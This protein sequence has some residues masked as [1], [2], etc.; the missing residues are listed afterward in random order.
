MRATHSAGSQPLR[1]GAIADAA[2]LEDWQTDCLERLARVDG[3]TP[4]RHPLQ[5]H[6]LEQ[7]SSR[8][9]LARADIVLSFAAGPL[10]AWVVRA[11]RLG[12]WS[13]HFGAWQRTPR[14]GGCTL[15]TDGLASAALVRLTTEPHRA[16]LLR[17]GFYRP[18]PKHSATLRSMQ[19]HATLWPSQVCIDLLNGERPD[20]DLHAPVI[21]LDPPRAPA[22]HR[23]PS[24]AIRETLGGLAAGA[25]KTLLH[26]HWSV[27][28][29]RRPIADFLDVGLRPQI[30][31]LPLDGRRAFAADPFGLLHEGRHVALYE[32]YDRRTGRGSIASFELTA[33][34]FANDS[35]IALGPEIHRSYPY[36]FEHE[37]AIY[38]IPETSAAREVALYRAEEYPRRW[39]R[40][41]T[42]LAGVDA[43][44]STVFR[45]EGRWW[46]AC[47]SAAERDRCADL[48][49][50]HAEALEGPWRSHAGNP[51]KSDVRSARPG[52]TPFVHEYTLYRP[53]QDC[54]RTYGGR[55]VINRVLRLSP[56][57]FEEEPAAIVSPDP[58]G[59][60]PDGLHTLSAFGGLTLLDGKR[61]A[62]VPAELRRT[63]TGLWKPSTVMNVDRG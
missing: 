9:D 37:G 18:E 32:R 42:L 10:P 33:A 31:W 35:A 2:R 60:F 29:V 24:A 19:T 57:A 41:A 11:P 16:V 34:G 47:A 46:L 36:V 50:W 12:V 7:A 23:A 48:F 25:L 22:G 38:G 58:A 20:A 62:L 63:L 45:H 26:E 59:P 14:A 52:G 21:L 4:A 15:P 54:S 13:F 28:V 30:Q 61:R 17:E 8:D 3:I 53:A 44:D 39:T 55:I 56:T 43:V 1:V 5:T 40:V 49:L 51:V 27:G 6:R